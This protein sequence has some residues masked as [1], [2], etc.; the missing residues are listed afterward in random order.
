MPLRDRAR[1][2]VLD[3]FYGNLCRFDKTA[4]FFRLFYQVA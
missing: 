3:P 1:L 2:F 4:M